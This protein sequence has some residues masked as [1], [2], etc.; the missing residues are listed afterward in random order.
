V[1]V[2]TV[3]GA[4]PQFV[5]AAAVSGP[6][7]KRAHEVLLHTGQHYD[8]AMSDAFFR[9]LDIP[10]PDYELNVGSDSHARQTGRMLVGIE[11]VIV[12][13][14]PD[15]VLLYGDTNST[16]AGALAAAKAC[17]PVV[18]VE[19]GLRSFNR[20]MPEEV[21]R[22]VTDQLSAV[23]CCSSQRAADQLRTEGITAGVHVTG[24]VMRDVL[25]R[26][27]PRLTESR[28][29]PFGVE[30]RRY[31]LLTIHRAHNTDDVQR[32]VSLIDAIAEAAS[33]PVIFPVHPRT[34]AVL[35]TLGRKED[36]R[37]RL[38]DP[39]AY[40]DMLA[41]ERHARL[42]LTDSGGVQKE[43][44]W[45]GVPCVTLRDETEWIETVDAGWNRLVGSRSDAVRQALNGWR[46]PAGRPDLYGDGRSAERVADLITNA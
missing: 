9:E 35:A 8:E 19:A 44:Y 33:E 40:G 3:V 14:R 24:D 34:R 28:L 27:L 43:A 18:H 37:I 46:L 6:L 17:V 42:V 5:K 7:R 29:A 36:A 41:L 10:A 12:S 45:L 22:V 11:Q 25:E 32:L 31:L 4:R 23:L 13:E 30:P 16:L 38:I 1:K 15:R 2:L 26:T 21:N 39:V 20:G